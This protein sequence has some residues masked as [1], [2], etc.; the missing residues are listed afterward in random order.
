MNT[1]SSAARAVG[2][3]AGF[4]P[5]REAS[6]IR[7]FSGKFDVEQ[8][9]GANLFCS[10]EKIIIRRHNNPRNPDGGLDC[11][12]RLGVRAVLCRFSFLAFKTIAPI[13]SRQPLFPLLR[14]RTVL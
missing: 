14:F 4:V 8:E 6:S 1:I 7:P 3:L 13:P 11:A 12:K 10:R 9:Q 2:L 5:Q